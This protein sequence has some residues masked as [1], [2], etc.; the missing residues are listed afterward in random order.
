MIPKKYFIVIK[1]SDIEKYS[2]PNKTFIEVLDDIQKGRKY[3]GKLDHKYY[4]INKLEPYANLVWDM[5]VHWEIIRSREKSCGL[6]T[7]E[8]DDKYK[9]VDEF[10][11]FKK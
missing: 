2:N 4:I 10:D 6:E 8:N 3:D 9:K 5:I 7:Y 11:I 1:E